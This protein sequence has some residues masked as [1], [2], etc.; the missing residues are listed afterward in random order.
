[1]QWEDFFS[2]HPK[3]YHMAWERAWPSIVEHVRQ[4]GIGRGKL[5]EQRPVACVKLRVG[6]IELPLP[7][8]SRNL[9]AHQAHLRRKLVN[10][11]QQASGLCTVLR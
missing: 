2:L 10:L 11:V 4:R 7:Y 8:Q 1:M 6:G 3:L 5:A 9:L